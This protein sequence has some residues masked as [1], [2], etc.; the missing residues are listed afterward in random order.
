ML[1]HDSSE[2]AK[3]TIPLIT[4][5]LKIIPDFVRKWALIVMRIWNIY[6]HCNFSHLSFSH[7]TL[8]YLYN[9]YTMHTECWAQNKTYYYCIDSQ[10][11]CNF[12]HLSFSYNT[13]FPEWH[14]YYMNNDKLYFL[15]SFQS[16]ETFL[17]L[18]TLNRTRSRHEVSKMNAILCWKL[19]LDFRFLAFVYSWIK[20]YKN[21]L[22]FQ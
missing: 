12:S 7:N 10:N 19:F 15:R 1:C 3:N 8:K 6:N 16:P 11:H 22:C 4:L 2:L 14:L 18:I 13:L 21:V 20:V 5:L 9:V 17:L